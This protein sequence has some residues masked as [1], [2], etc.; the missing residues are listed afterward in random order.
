MH[1]KLYL[2]F[3]DTQELDEL[4]Q[5]T[6]SLLSSFDVGVLQNQS[7]SVES[8]VRDEGNTIC[9]GAD[10]NDKAAGLNGTHIAPTEVITAAPDAA[11]NP[12]TP[13]SST[14]GAVSRTK[15][16]ALAMP[17]IRVDVVWE[18]QRRAK[19]ASSSSWGRNSNKSN[20]AGNSTSA[21]WGP[22]SP[23][24]KGGGRPAFESSRPE[25]ASLFTKHSG[26][27]PSLQLGWSESDTVVAAAAAITA[28]GS[29]GT[30]SNARSSV[31]TSDDSSGAV[32]STGRVGGFLRRRHTVTTALEAGTANETRPF[33]PL[34]ENDDSTS[35]PRKKS[36][37]REGSWRWLS[38]WQVR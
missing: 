17:E 14:T 38:P 27:P 2:S 35:L 25:L 33:D 1:H 34:L 29:G 15:G 31:S 23:S 30:E 21:N 28:L 19:A 18:N 5:N 24:S 6:T 36:N 37:P 4:V 22:E 26:P 16:S 8:T 12:P 7:S 32:R 11:V 13:V 20:G 3:F 10:S 9:A